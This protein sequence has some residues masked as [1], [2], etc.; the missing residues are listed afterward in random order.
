M[1]EEGQHV[2]PFEGVDAVLRQLDASG[3]ALA[4]VSSN[5]AVNC[6]RVLGD[7]N[8]RRFAHVECGA[9]IF[10]KRRRIARVLKSARVPRDRAIYVGDQLADAEAARAAG[11]AFGAVAWGYA[12][13]HSLIAAKPE[14]E[15]ARL[16]D[17]G[18]LAHSREQVESG[19][20]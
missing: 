15:F 17:L 9:S 5:S 13:F 2:V 8:W 18:Q 11:V 12:S 14:A 19:L 10:G 7:D 6:R 20:K 4:L 16:K 3:A 1:R